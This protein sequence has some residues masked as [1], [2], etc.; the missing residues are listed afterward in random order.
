MNKKLLPLIL[1]TLFLAA[2]A[3]ASFQ[4]TK[5]VGVTIATFT[6]TVDAYAEIMNVHPS[7]NSSISAEA[8]VFQATGTGY[9]DYITIQLKRVGSGTTGTLKL[10]VYNITGTYG[11]TAKPN[12][13]LETSTT[14]T[15]IEDLGTDYNIATFYFEGTKLIVTGNQLAFVLYADTGDFFDASNYTSAAAHDTGG[16]YGGN[17]AYYASSAWTEFT[18]H[19]FTMWTVAGTSTPQPTPTPIDTSLRYTYTLKEQSTMQLATGYNTANGTQWALQQGKNYVYQGYV[20]NQSNPYVSGTY[21]VW[22]SG[23]WYK[24]LGYSPQD[25]WG[26]ITNDALTQQTTGSISNGYFGFTMPFTSFGSWLPDNIEAYQAIRV[27]GTVTGTTETFE[28]DYVAVYTAQNVVYITPTPPPII[29]PTNNDDTITTF[30]NFAVPLLLMLLPAC[31]LGWLTGWSKWPIL[32]GLAIGTGLGVV[33]VPS[34]PLWLVVMVA[35][36]L[37]GFAYSEMRGGV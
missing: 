23:L 21:A 26:N 8:Q 19:D 18:D 2:A 9:L 13:L 17:M 24:S 6:G 29:N 34:F 35:L 4:Q 27:N 11:T 16:T 1:I 28:E 31:I 5:A 36:G 22:R 3:F 10:A 37:A 15:A 7:T 30:V 32:I 12:T 33:F 20:T 14:V 25:A